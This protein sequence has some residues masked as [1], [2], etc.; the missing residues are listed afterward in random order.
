[1]TVTFFI[2]FIVVCAYVFMIMQ[3]V[4]VGKINK[5][6]LILNELDFIDI[7]QVYIWSHSQFIRRHV[8]FSW[9]NFMVIIYIYTYLSF[10]KYIVNVYIYVSLLIVK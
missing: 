1:M 10:L 8:F 9:F 7:V 5:Y 3:M 4:V 6:I 2:L